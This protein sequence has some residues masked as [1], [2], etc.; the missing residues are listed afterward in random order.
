MSS[1]VITVLDNID[2]LS[3][4]QCI[5]L[6]RGRRTPQHILKLLLQHEDYTVRQYALS[7]PDISE[8]MW[9]EAVRNTSDSFLMYC[10]L[11]NLGIPLSLVEEYAFHENDEVVSGI[12]YRSDLSLELMVTLAAHP[13]ED[14][15]LG[16]ANVKVK[17]LP[18]EAGVLL[19]AGREQ[20]GYKSISLSI[21]KLPYS[22]F[23]FWLLENGYPVEWKLG[24]L[25]LSLMLGWLSDNQFSPKVG[26]YCNLVWQWRE[27]D[28]RAYVAA[29]TGVGGLPG[30]W[31]VKVLKTL[32]GAS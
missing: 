30:P 12:A 27:A 32:L 14:V 21:P 5:Y 10:A 2:G 4:S 11:G 17:P 20:K 31:V 26:E 8:D 22:T 29:Q 3:I 16:V 24:E 1:N 9:L 19:T 23:G 25:P 7:C 28:V 6:T 18:V 13:S 15:A